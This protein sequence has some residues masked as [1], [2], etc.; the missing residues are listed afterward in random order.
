MKVG[1]HYLEFITQ[2]THAFRRV[3]ILCETETCREPKLNN[4]SLQRPN[5][6]L[7]SKQTN[8]SILSL[9]AQAAELV[10]QTRY[11]KEFTA[12]FWAVRVHRAASRDQTGQSPQPWAQHSV[13]FS[14]QILY[15]HLAC[16]IISNTE[17]G[18]SHR[19]A[20]SVGGIQDMGGLCKARSY[21]HRVRSLA[22]ARACG[23]PALQGLD[24]PST[25]NTRL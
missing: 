15:S 22:G 7:L 8:S 2:F 4:I 3:E 14:A 18:A 23:A 9:G 11:E 19:R 21:T 6:K 25:A 17:Q 5:S 1:A 12:P 13:V 20:Y 16:S 10:Q 24:G